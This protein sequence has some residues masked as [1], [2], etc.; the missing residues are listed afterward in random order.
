MGKGTSDRAA[1][2]AKEFAGKISGNDSLTRKGK[3]QKAK[4]KV[5][6]A[7]GKVA[8]AI[9]DVTGCSRRWRIETGMMRGP[10]RTHMMT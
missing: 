2:T 6:Q 1:G 5:R 9:G 3:T 4:G 10:R 7:A 8:D